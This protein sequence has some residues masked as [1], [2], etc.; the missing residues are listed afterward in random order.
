MTQAV[1]A[2]VSLGREVRQSE[3][4]VLIAVYLFAHSMVSL[5]PVS[6]SDRLNDGAGSVQPGESEGVFISRSPDAP[7]HAKPEGTGLEFPKFQWYHAA[8]S[9]KSRRPWGPGGTR[10]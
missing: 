8:P 6:C 9:R 3:R 5:R 1:K 2:V 7:Y 4:D 10:R